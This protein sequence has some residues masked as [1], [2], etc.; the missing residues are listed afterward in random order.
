MRL[1]TENFGMTDIL[2]I[3][4]H[5]IKSLINYKF[6]LTTQQLTIRIMNVL[7]KVS[8]IQQLNHIV[9][10]RQGSI[11]T[12]FMKMFLLRNQEFGEG[13]GNPL[14]YSCLENP[15]GGGAW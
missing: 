4:N 15:M 6:I 1:K 11:L 2:N 8:V 13:N 7:E 3:L 12:L 9:K 14:Q 10:R 5:L